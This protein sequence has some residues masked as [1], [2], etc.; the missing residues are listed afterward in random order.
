MTKWLFQEARKPTIITKVVDLMILNCVFIIACLPII[1]I[2][3]SLTSLYHVTLKMVDPEKDY[4][5]LK[6]FIKS[7]KVH[8]IQSTTV[9]G[10]VL[11]KVALLAAI[12]YLINLTG[13][14]QPSLMITMP[15]LLLVTIMGLVVLYLFPLLAY[16]DNTIFHTFKNALIISFDQMAKSIVL[17]LIALV[18]II[19]IPLFVTQI[20]FLWLLMAFSL[21]AYLQSLILKTIFE[22]YCNN[23]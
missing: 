16:F 4:F 23:D 14:G 7:F 1:T 9:M 11:I 5:L 3:A 21:T 20:W 18:I 6:D 12:I 15:F 2:G 17:F 19:V 13:D 22:S 8:F 10:I